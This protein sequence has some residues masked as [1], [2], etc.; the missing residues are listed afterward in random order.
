[1]A[2]MKVDMTEFQ[3]VVDSVYLQAVSWDEMLAALVPKMV[4][5]LERVKDNKL[6]L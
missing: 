2:V 6:D 1:M 4:C 5:S 3:L